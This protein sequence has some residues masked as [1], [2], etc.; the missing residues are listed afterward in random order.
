M[1][2]SIGPYT[3]AD[4][5]FTNVG[6]T[7]QYNTGVILALCGLMLRHGVLAMQGN[8]MCLTY[9][10]RENVQCQGPRLLDGAVNKTFE[11]FTYSMALFVNYD[12]V[13]ER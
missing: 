3:G 7:F 5:E 8:R 11:F 6:L 2:C 4:L 13:T 1:L 9:Y 10:M 12:Y